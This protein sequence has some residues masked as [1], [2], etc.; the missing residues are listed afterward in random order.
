MSGPQV[1]KMLL[2][3]FL[4]RPCMQVSTVQPMDKTTVEVANMKSLSNGSTHRWSV[5]KF[6]V[7][8][9]LKSS[10]KS[11]RWVLALAHTLLKLAFLPKQVMPQF[12]DR[13]H[14]NGEEVT[15]SVELIV[16]D[17]TIAPVFNEAEL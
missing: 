7:F 4:V 2:I 1:D 17:Y 10:V 12:Q 5:Q 9:N 15:F 6:P 3:Q 11:T 13:Q 8:L 16:F 14:D